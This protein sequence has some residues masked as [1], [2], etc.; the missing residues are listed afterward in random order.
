MLFCIGVIGAFFTQHLEKESK[1]WPPAGTLHQRFCTRCQ[2][3]SGGEDSGVAQNKPLIG[4][5]S[6]PG[7]FS[8]SYRGAV[9]N[10]RARACTM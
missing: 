3:L 2:Y 6:H 9:Q 5:R 8:E 7:S 1:T 10:W 4:L